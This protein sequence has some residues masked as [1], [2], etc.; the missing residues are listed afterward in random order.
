MQRDPSPPSLQPCLPLCLHR[1]GI[2]ACD[3]RESAAGV[4]KE[5]IW[6]IYIAGKVEHISPKKRFGRRVDLGSRISCKAEIDSS[7]V[8]GVFH[9]SVDMG[10][11][12]PSVSFATP[13]PWPVLPCHGVQG[14]LMRAHMAQ[15]VN[16]HTSHLSL[17]SSPL[18]V[19]GD[20]TSSW[21]VKG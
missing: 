9:K 18:P 19:A 7:I 20:K 21:L 14:T 17:V 11:W 15:T 4:R 5:L 16:T 1:R 13:D 10:D 8:V 12:P 2:S 6:S 3:G